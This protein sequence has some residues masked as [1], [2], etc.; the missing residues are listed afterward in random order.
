[1][2][3]TGNAVNKK[4]RRENNKVE[5]RNLLHISSYEQKLKPV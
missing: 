5:T 3:K 4:R 1:M 2:C